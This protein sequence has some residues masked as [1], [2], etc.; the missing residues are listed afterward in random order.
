MNYREY[1][2]PE[3]EQYRT[4]FAWNTKTGKSAR[5]YYDAEEWHKSTVAFPEKPTG[6]VSGKAGDVMM[7]YLEYYTPENEQYRVVFT[8]STI[9]KKVQRYYYDAEAW[10]K[11][12]VA[13][14]D[15]AVE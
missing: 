8:W 6:E 4:V 15:N 1:Y 13:F 14:P 5:Y 11:S 2:T 7:S 10:H 3:G 12:T 9:K